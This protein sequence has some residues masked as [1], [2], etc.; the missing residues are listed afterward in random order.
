MKGNYTCFGH[1]KGVWDNRE[2]RYGFNPHKNNISG[3]GNMTAMPKQMTDIA[4]EI[5]KTLLVQFSRFE[6]NVKKLI[7]STPRFKLHKIPPM[8]GP[9][10]FNLNKNLHKS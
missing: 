5:I 3:S 4:L 8:V 7:I 6:I 2:E 1:V 10:H 9:T